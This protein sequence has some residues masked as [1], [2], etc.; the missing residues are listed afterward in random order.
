MNGLI[1]FP[2]RWRIAPDEGFIDN[3]IARSLYSKR[4]SNP[5]HSMFLPDCRVGLTRCNDE[6]IVC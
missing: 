4:R 2:R 6:T 5:L 1:P 3:V